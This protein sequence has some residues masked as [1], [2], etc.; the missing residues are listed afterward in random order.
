MKAKKH[1]YKKTENKYPAVIPVPKPFKN[2]IKGS[3]GI[4]Q[5]VNPS[6]NTANKNIKSDAK[7]AQNVLI[8][9]CESRASKFVKNK[10]SREASISLS[11]DIAYTVPQ[12]SPTINIEINNI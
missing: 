3:T 11:A 1:N 9:F 6:K 7:Q 8:T 5:G 4:P 2:T 10:K 12:A